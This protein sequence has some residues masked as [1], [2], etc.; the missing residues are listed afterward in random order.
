MTIKDYR[1]LKIALFPSY[2]NVLPHII[3]C[4]G[5]SLRQLG[6][7]VFFIPKVIENNRPSFNQ[8]VFHQLLTFNPDAVFFLGLNGFIR[9]GKN[10]KEGEHLLHVY[11]IPYVPFYFDFPMKPLLFHYKSN[12]MKAVFI[13]DRRYVPLLEKMGLE[14]VHYLPLGT[15]PNYFTQV[16]SKKDIYDVSFI[17]SVLGKNDIKEYHKK[18][19]FPLLEKAKTLVVQKIH[20]NNLNIFEDIIGNPE[21]QRHSFDFYNYVNFCHSHYYR[22]QYLYWLSKK[23]EVQI[24]GNARWLSVENNNIRVHP[25]VDYKTGLFPVF[26][27]TK[28]NLNFS[29]AQLTTAINQRLFDCYAS[30]NFL[31][32]DYKEDIRYLFE[33]DKITIP[34][35]TSRN[36]LLEK[37]EYYLINSDEREKITA[38]IKDVIT[39]KHT[40]K[41]RMQEVLDIV[42]A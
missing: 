25:A 41:H 16:S 26:N 42:A 33:D 28:I 11:K 8:E 19:S 7:S 4:M 10:M 2:G 27:K 22:K 15:N 39:N 3:K 29:A 18:L 34:F 36:D 17:G 23:Y 24:F 30:G 9:I 6:V 32:T 35:F 13:W 20:N 31:L 38:Q 21:I 5:N 37:V 1:G 14:N 12:Y 40:W